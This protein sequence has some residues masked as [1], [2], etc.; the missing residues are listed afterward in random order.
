N[1]G[2]GNDELYGGLLGDELYGGLGSDYLYGDGGGDL[3][4]AGVSTTASEPN[5][6]HIMYGGSGADEI[7]GELGD[8]YIDA[9]TEDNTVY[10]YAGN[11]TIIAESG[12]DYI[13][14]GS[15]DDDIS[16][17]DG[18]NTVFGGS[19]RETVTTGS[20]RDYIDVRGG[21]ASSHNI[22]SG[23]DNDLIYGDA[24]SDV[25]DSGGGD[26]TVHAGD[27][28]NTITTGTGADT[29]TSGA[30]PDT[31]DTG[32]D[33]DVVDAG[34]GENHVAG[35]GDD[36]VGT[37]DG[38]DRIYASDG[39]DQVDAGGDDDLLV[40]GY[41]DDVLIGGDG[42]DIIWGG[43]QILS[44]GHFR[45][46]D[47]SDFANPPDFDDAEAANPTGY[48][49]P[50]IMP[51]ALAGATVD[52]AFDDGEDTLHGDGD[53]DWLFGGGMTDL[54][55]GGAGNDYVDGGV[56]DDDVRGGSGEDVVRGGGNDDVVTGGS[57]IDQLYGD[58]GSDVLFG[59]AGNGN[60]QAGQ[61]LWGGEDID[62][63]Y[64][65]A[66]STDVATEAGFRGDELNGDS[67]N[68][69]L[70]GNIR[71]EIL[72]GGTGNDFLHG[73]WLRGPGYAVSPYAARDGAADRLFGDTGEDQIF[74]GG[75]PDEMY[76]GGDS[77]W[78]EGQNN[79][80][81][82]Y[83]GGG[84]DLMILDTNPEFITEF[85]DIFDGHWGNRT[86]GDVI[87][88]NA[89]DIL[90]T[91]GTQDHDTILMKEKDVGIMSGAG[92]PEDGRLGAGLTAELSLVINGV[93]VGP[94][95]IPDDPLNATLQDLVA[96]INAA[97]DLA[98]PF[99]GFTAESV[100]VVR[101]RDRIRFETV[102]LG[103]ETEF[104]I[105]G[106]NAVTR[107]VLKL[108][109]GMVGA[110]L[111]SVEYNMGPG[112]EPMTVG[113]RDGDGVPLVEQFRISGLM[114]SD[115][116]GFVSGPEGVDLSSLN[117]RSN[118]W[119]GV[120]DGGPG[121]DMLIGGGGRDRLDGGKGSDALYG[122]DGDDRLWGDMGNGTD[123][124]HDRL[125]AGQGNDDLIGGVGGNELYAWSFDPALDITGPFVVTDT[126]VP[127][128]IVDF[129]VFVDPD[130]GL[131]YDH[132]GD[133]AYQVEDT[134]LNRMLGSD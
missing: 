16:A 68:D 127:D 69:W 116:V 80:D 44:E 115:T 112:E 132:D 133:G 4:V 39:N 29:V 40:G 101:I 3:L 110:P 89:T 119:V 85:G 49:P 118:D 27:G 60:D 53:G 26:D 2:A 28:T 83:G 126:P 125:F 94:V 100:N 87:D 33:P 11:D 76:G 32:D 15:G 62:Y 37:G 122:F 120:F 17:G 88:D 106:T 107:D 23:G 8:D 67:G 96:D 1:G 71:Q 129:G 14:S 75:G 22:V 10:A 84:I 45:S 124:D 41:G 58:N 114:G 77:D 82:L 99:S 102:G 57:G 117:E 81:L 42:S 79:Q 56:G 64:A 93:T 47:P 24:G 108:A 131:L 134:G 72:T 5:T 91:E 90:L 61:R 30:G 109:D 128:G 74:G 21:D 31:I 34:D 123:I 13:D 130:T 51:V 113:W 92:V 19:G 98:L 121:D 43:E 12:N 105:T 7:H 9:G 36:V 54:L 35:A 70:Y 55:L 66:P 46:I 52:G 63:L 25:I 38:D 78:L 18:N 48:T 20:G 50:K 86:A 97:L 65:Y 59:D 6:V 111:L 95:Q 103:R 73:D 104:E